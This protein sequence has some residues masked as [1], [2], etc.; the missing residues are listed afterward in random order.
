MKGPKEPKADEM[1]D[2]PDFRRFK[3]KNDI[4]RSTPLGLKRF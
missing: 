4:N 1:A 3:D 2:A